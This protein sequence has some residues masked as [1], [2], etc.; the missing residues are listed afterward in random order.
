MGTQDTKLEFDG[1]RVL[2]LPSPVDWVRYGYY[3]KKGASTSVSANPLDEF[4]L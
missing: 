2:P 3:H 4:K 1:S